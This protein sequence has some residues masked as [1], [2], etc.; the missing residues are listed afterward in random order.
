[1]IIKLLLDLIIGV[2]TVLFFLLPNVPSFNISLVNSL[3][4]V[5][6]IIFNNLSFLGIFIRVSTIKLII[7]LFLIAWQFDHIWD[8]IWWVLEKIPFLNIKK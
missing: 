5:F 4:N 7:P 1:M 2:I 8:M 6:N 3:N